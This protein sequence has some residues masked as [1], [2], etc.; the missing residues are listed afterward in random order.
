MTKC[1]VCAHCAV[2]CRDKENGLGHV[3]D[4][5]RVGYLGLEGERGKR[6]AEARA[7]SSI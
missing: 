6:G 3:T 4:L 1:R 7:N 2:R 5:D